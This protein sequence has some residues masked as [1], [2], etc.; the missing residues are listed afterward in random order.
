[1]DRVNSFKLHLGAESA[2]LGHCGIREV[3]ILRRTSKFLAQMHEW[4][5]V[6]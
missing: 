5:E 4:M 6:L 2:V 3:G 1:M